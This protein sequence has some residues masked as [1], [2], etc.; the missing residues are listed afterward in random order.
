MKVF[1]FSIVHK[2]DDGF[3]S[4][5]RFSNNLEEI[6]KFAEYEIERFK[7]WHP[8]KYPS[9]FKINK[10]ENGELSTCNASTLVKIGCQIL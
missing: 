1:Y 6:K 9:S 10:F 5:N 8:N 7:S 4:V 2:H 3:Y